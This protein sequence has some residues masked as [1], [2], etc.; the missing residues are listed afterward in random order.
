MESGAPEVVSCDLG[1]LM[2]VAGVA[3]RRGIPLRARH[4]AEVL[5]G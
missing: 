4:I 5:D 1:C 2:H 3:H